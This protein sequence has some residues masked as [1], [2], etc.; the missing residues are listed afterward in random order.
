MTDMCRWR[1]FTLNLFSLKIQL[2]ANSFLGAK[3]ATVNMKAWMA[4]PA[5]MELMSSS[6][7]PSLSSS[8]PSPSPSKQEINYLGFSWE[9]S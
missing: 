4:C 7:S 6:S 5:L 3:E 2:S 8:S 9:D 1:N